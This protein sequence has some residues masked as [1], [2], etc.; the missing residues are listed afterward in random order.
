MTTLVV[1][2]IY[3]SKTYCFT[4]QSN[5]ICLPNSTRPSKNDF[6]KEGMAMKVGVNVIG[7]IFPHIQK[8]S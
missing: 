7:V 6:C 4:I 5:A 8:V 2:V 3:W 1:I